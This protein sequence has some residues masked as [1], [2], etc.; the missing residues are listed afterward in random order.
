[1]STIKT[2]LPGQRHTPSVGAERT[3]GAAPQTG[4]GASENIVGIRLQLRDGGVELTH[5][6]SLIYATL[7]AMRIIRKIRFAFRCVQTEATKFARRIIRMLLSP[8]RKFAS[9]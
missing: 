1:M 9:V 6:T 7:V 2:L 8:F 3:V 5:I 4:R